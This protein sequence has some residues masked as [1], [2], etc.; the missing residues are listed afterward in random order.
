MPVRPEN[1]Q[2]HCG[3]L[4]KTKA[5]NEELDID[6]AVMDERGIHPEALFVYKLIWEIYSYTE[7]DE[8]GSMDLKNREIAL[9]KFKDFYRKGLNAFPMEDTIN[10]LMEHGMLKKREL[11]CF[12]AERFSPEK[13]EL[14]EVFA[15]KYKRFNNELGKEFWAAYPDMGYIDGRA[16]IPLKSIKRFMSREE[17]YTAYAKSIGNRQDKHKHVLELIR[18]SIE[19]KSSFTN[20]NIESFLLGRVWESIEEFINEDGNAYMGAVSGSIEYR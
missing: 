5:V 4:K 12:D 3:F 14:N 18:W 16:E 6:L 8:E 13:V 17:L 11:K 1:R 2:R 9:A 20:M 10:Y 19:N 7:Q 15:S